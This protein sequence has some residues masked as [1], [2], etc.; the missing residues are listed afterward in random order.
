MRYLTK[1]I[2]VRISK[3]VPVDRSAEVGEGFQW[4]T[5]KTE[6]SHA[7][8]HVIRL[9]IDED[10]IMEELGNKAA[11]S[12]SG[13]SRGLGGLIVAKRIGKGVHLT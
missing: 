3:R 4:K 9:E 10:A 8:Q 6:F 13:R 11:R 2:T 5:Y 1:T 12:K 7:E